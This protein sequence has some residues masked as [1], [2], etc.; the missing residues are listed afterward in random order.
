MPVQDL[1]GA[2]REALG[3]LLIRVGIRETS[4]IHQ[5][6]EEM[7]DKEVL[8]TIMIHIILA[9]KVVRAVVHSM[10]EV[11]T[12]T[13]EVEALLKVMIKTLFVQE[14]MVEAVVR[15]TEVEVA[16][17]VGAHLVAMIG[18]RITQEVMVEMVGPSIMVVG[19]QAAVDLLT[20]ITKIHTTMVEAVDREERS[21]QEAAMVIPEVED[22]ILIIIDFPEMIDPII[23]PV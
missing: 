12:V 3:V 19:A 1:L 6:M 5:I 20:E 2:P 4:I 16:M 7:E 15:S 9:N 21:I 18:I 11:A 14:E 23:I 22:P 13:L 17:M 10:E 8:S